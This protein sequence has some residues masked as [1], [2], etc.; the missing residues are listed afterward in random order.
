MRSKVVG[1]AEFKA[2]CLRLIEEMSRDRE[3][4]TI[5][6]RG[7][8]VARLVPIEEPSAKRPLVGAMRGTVLSYAEPF[9]PVTD[10]ADW[11]AT[12]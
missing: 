7:R 9:A 10:V 8:P 3:P 1:A 4:V 6:K 12:R 5:T 2:E 11:V